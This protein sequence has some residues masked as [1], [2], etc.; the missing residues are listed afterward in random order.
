MRKI[1]V[2]LLGLS[3]SIILSLSSCTYRN[4]QEIL[5]SVCDTSNT[6]Y[7]TFVSNFI[8]TNCNSKGGCHGV[9]PGSISLEAYSDVSS[10]ASDILDRI[11]SGN[12]PKGGTKLD[13]CSIERFETWVNK[14]AR[15]N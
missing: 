10:V 12:M 1:I 5:G 14:G 4:T 6:K 13:D 3:F 9:S 15:N 11:K 8:S 7:S 2:G